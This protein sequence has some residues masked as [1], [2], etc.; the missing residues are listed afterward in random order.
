M[1]DRLLTEGVNPATLDID[2]R[3]SLE[4]AQL[5]ND[6]DAKVAAA[7]KVELPHNRRASATGRATVLLWRGDER[8]TGRS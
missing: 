8:A 4:I 7:I 1:L 2:T 3:S 6:E 5:I